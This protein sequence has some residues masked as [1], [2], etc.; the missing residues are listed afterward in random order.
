MG[1]IWANS[2]DSHLVEP[3][4]L[5]TTRLPADLARRM[6]RSEKDPDGRWETV[7]VDGKEFRRR[8]PG[9]GLVDPVTGL[10]VDERAP[11]ANDPHLRLKDLD[12]EGI[13]AELIYPSIGIWTSSVDD[14]GLLAGGDQRHQRLGHRVPA[15]VA[16]FRVHGQYA[17]AVDPRRGGGDRAGRRARVQGGLLPGRSAPGAGRLPVSGD[18]E[19]VWAALEST[20]T[21][22]AF[23]IGTEP[24]DAGAGPTA[25]TTGVPAVRS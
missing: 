9:S 10:T 13:W 22:L 24:H 3:D 4:D 19:P 18:W 17:V 8:M 5:F 25:C 11:G 6:P 15:G 1:K 12:E 7:H 20:G 16:A 21:V 14:P 2:G 23:H